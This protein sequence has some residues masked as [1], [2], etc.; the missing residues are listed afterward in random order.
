MYDRFLYTFVRVVEC[1]SFSKAAERLFLSRVSVMKQVNS[2]EDR[3]GVKLLERTNAGIALTAAGKSLYQDALRLIA[4]SDAAVA[5]ARQLAGENRTVIRIGA[6]FLNPGQPLVRLWEQ[7]REDNPQYRIKIVA[8]SDDH[9]LMTDM[10]SLLGSRFDL[11]IG[12]CDSAQWGQSFGFLELGDYRISCAV[13]KTHRLAGKKRL[14]PDDLKGETV[15]MVEKG[16]SPGNDR[17]R[18]WLNMNYPDVRIRD[19]FHYYD[20]ETFNECLR[21][22]CVLLTFDFWAGVH[23]SLVTLPMEWNFS[24]PYGILYPKKTTT[25]VTAFLEAIRTGI[26]T[27]KINLSELFAGR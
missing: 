3:V 7:I 13:P 17:V 20:L 22:G 5:R 1:G 10:P 26:F 9:E 19:V 16:D 11:M 15:M 6:S 14:V 8:F 24:V 25:G 27:G 21:S 2:L 4:D 23:P 12:V 18:E